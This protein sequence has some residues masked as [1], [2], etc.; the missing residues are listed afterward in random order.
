MCN[1]NH[2]GWDVGFCSKGVDS[3]INP[4]AFAWLDSLDGIVPSFLWVHYFG[5]HSP[6]YNGGNRADKRLDPGYEG[7]SLR[8]RSSSIGSCKKRSRSRI[9]I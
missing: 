3:R 7:R 2:T 5:A 4:E 8:R 9:A 1:A 6:Y